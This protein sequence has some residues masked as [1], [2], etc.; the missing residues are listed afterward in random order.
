MIILMKCLNEEKVVERVISDFHG[1]SWVSS[2]VVIDGGSTDYTVQELNKFGKVVVYSHPWIDWYHDMEIIQSNIA[3]SYVPHGKLCFILDFDEKMSPQLKAELASIDETGL[4]TDVAHVARRTYGV[5]RYPD[6]PYAVLDEDGWPI[7]MNQIG[8][9][10]DY[11]CRLIKRQPGMN[12]INSPHHQLFPKTLSNINIPVDI[13]HFEKDDE[14]DR[15]RIEKKWA[16]AQARRKELGLTCD[17]FECRVEPEL[18]KYTQPEA[19]K[20]D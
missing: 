6:S 20:N 12:W 15:L 1:E 18:H 5:M 10:P 9:Y 3:L 8:Q 2:I 7:V 16:R 19:W 14:R 11:Q 17:V 13:L 4:Q